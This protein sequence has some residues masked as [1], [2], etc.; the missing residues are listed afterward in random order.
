MESEFY[1]C[2]REREPVCGDVSGQD[3]VSLNPKASS[4]QPSPPFGEERE[5]ES[6]AALRFWGAMRTTSFRG[7]LTPA[8]F[9]TSW[10]GGRGMRSFRA[11]GG[12]IE[13]FNIRRSIFNWEWAPRKNIE[14]RTLNAEHRMNLEAPRGRSRRTACLGL[15][16]FGPSAR[17]ISLASVGCGAASYLCR[18]EGLRGA[19]RPALCA[20][21]GLWSG[22]A[23]PPYRGTHGT[24]SLSY[25]WSRSH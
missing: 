11:W 16:S 25:I 24:A 17:K 20:R 12:L 19:F 21:D 4:P 18:G 22:A 13:T 7:I 9:P 5:T 15:Y 14:R 2:G 3:V 1:K 6:L 10:R 8:F 23:A